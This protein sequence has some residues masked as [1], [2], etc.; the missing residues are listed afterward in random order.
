MPRV[1]PSLFFISLFFCCNNSFAQKDS[2]AKIKKAHFSAFARI[3]TSKKYNP[4]IAIVRSAI[5]PGWGQ[6]VNKKY[7]KIPLVYAALGIT[8]GIFF[9][10]LKQFQEANS[11]Y[12][13]SIDGDTSNDYQIPQPYYSVKDQPDRIKTFRNEVRQNVDYSVLFFI[14]FWGLNVIDAAVDA[15]LKTFD[16][17]DNLNVQIKP[18]Y[19]PLANTNGIS[20]VLNIGRD[21]PKK[22]AI[23]P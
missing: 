6:A 13:N 8:A 16:V 14:V 23:S 21:H 19:S 5:L 12:K 1:I 22:P 3:D 2:T 17:S 4:K 20:L 15:H 11:A 7:W 10:N 18:G 9:H